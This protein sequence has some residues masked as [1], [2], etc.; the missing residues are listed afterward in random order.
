MS[1]AVLAGIGENDPHWPFVAQALR[2]AALDVVFV[3]GLTTQ[4]EAREIETCAVFVVSAVG[5][6]SAFAH[7]LAWA[8]QRNVVVYVEPT[9]VPSDVVVDRS[10]FVFAT[11]V[12]TS[13]SELRDCL[14]LMQPLFDDTRLPKD[15]VEIYGEIYARFKQGSLTRGDQSGGGRES[16][17]PRA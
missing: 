9:W 5:S 4:E 2:D 6:A 15:L 17:V 12:V 3:S 16:S 13:E 8:S 7:G 1:R 14:R 11:A 10:D